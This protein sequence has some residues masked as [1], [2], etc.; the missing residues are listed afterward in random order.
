MHAQNWACASALECMGQVWVRVCVYSMTGQKADSSLGTISN[1]L[2][3]R[4]VSG[5]SKQ[6]ATFSS[7]LFP[8]SFSTLATMSAKRD[9]FQRKGLNCPVISILSYSALFVTQI[10]TVYSQAGFSTFFVLVGRPNN[11]HTP[12]IPPVL[13]HLT[14]LVVC[15]LQY[16]KWQKTLTWEATYGP[17]MGVQW[18]NDG[19]KCC[20]AEKHHYRMSIFAIFSVGSNLKTQML[21][22]RLPFCHLWNNCLGCTINFQDS[23]CLFHY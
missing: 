8:K 15:Q 16:H 6:S 7:C 14:D 1:S 5:T 20:P 12:D 4:I 18:K 3:S 19:Y 21:R 9:C 13:I 17:N 2:T 22:L 10:N 11:I 23:F